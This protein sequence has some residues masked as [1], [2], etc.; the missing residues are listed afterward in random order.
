M[1]NAYKEAGV[2]IELGDKLSEALYD[3][4]KQTWDNRAD[5]F[6]K[7]EEA[8]ESFSGFRAMPANLLGDT[9]DL[10]LGMG[11]DGVGTKVEVAERTGDH[12]TVAFDLLAMVC[13]DAVVRGAEPIAVTT[14]LDVRKLED[15]FEVRRALGGLAAGYVRAAKA[16]GVVVVNGEVAELGD[17]I[18]GYRAGQEGSFN[19]NWAATALWAVHK[20]RILDGS[21]ILPGDAL[22]ALK[23]DGFRSNG[24]SLV[25]KILEKEYGSEWHK[26]EIYGFGNLGEEVQKPST[27]YS[28]AVVDM[29]GGYD[30]NREP[31]ASIDGVAHITGGG[32]PGKLGRMLFQ[33][34][35]GARIDAP[36]Y[37]SEGTMLTQ[38]LGKIDDRTAY[39][40]WN[41]GHGMVIATKNPGDVGLVAQEHGID[42]RVIGHVTDRPEVEIN[43]NGREIR[44]NHSARNQILT[45]TK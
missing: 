28:R 27:I 3:A 9:T 37:P 39:S 17:R 29:F 7:L 42:S 1:N 33:F 36:F 20:D 16:A 38:V 8:Y 43:S 34:G 5:T 22:V 44:W 41:M 23:E 35:L 18:G 24:I 2:N 19:Y 10:Y 4:A 30:L 14:T 21:R 25:R 32:L 31:K 6:G 12:S 15:N 13:D 45:F 26:Q 40:T 11:D